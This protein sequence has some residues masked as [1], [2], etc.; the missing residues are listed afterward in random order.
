[1]YSWECHIQQR[2][3]IYKKMYLLYL[4]AE[5]NACSYADSTNKNISSVYAISQLRRVKLDFKFDQTS[6]AEN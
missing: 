6:N 2:Q 4:E 1:M 5:K 3:V